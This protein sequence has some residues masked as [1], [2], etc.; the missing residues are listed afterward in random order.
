M[1]ANLLQTR[2]VTFA[3]DKFLEDREDL[4]PVLVNPFQIVP[5]PGLET[6]CFQPLLEERTGYINVAAKGLDR[7]ATEEKSVEHR[8]LTLAGQRVEVISELSC[9]H[10]TPRKKAV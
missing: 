5:E 10:R 6:W 7:V 1:R 4:F 2:A 8:G 3:A 9:S